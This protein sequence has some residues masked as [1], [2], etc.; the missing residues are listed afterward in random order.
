MTPQEIFDTVSA[1]LLKQGCKSLFQG[2]SCQYRNTEGLKCAVGILIPDE[3]YDPLM[4][5]SLD[6]L[7]SWPALSFLCEHK[8]LLRRLQ[9]IH[10]DSDPKNWKHELISLAENYS[11]HKPE[12]LL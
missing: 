10:D 12:H 5:G 1:H 8:E 9:R 7:L 3:R 11:F 4:E 2:V 6:T